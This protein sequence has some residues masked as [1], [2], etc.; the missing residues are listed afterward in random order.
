MGAT[1]TGEWMYRQTTTDGKPA[2]M[3]Y[4][5]GKR[6][7]EAYYHNAEDKSLALRELVGFSNANEILSKSRYGEN[8]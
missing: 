1:E 2:D 7:A 6:I 8:L 5:I 4:W 3:A